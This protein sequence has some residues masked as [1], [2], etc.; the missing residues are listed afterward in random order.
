VEPAALLEQMVR[1][2]HQELQVHLE[3]V[4]QVE[5]QEVLEHQE[6][7]VLLEQVDRQVR[8][9]LDL[10]PSIVQALEEYFYRMVPQML[11]RLR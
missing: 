10:Q 7:T 11:Q 3:P 5:R 2:D 6:P 1:V 4:V 8:A 9:A